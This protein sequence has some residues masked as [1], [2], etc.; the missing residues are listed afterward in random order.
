M[1]NVVILFTP[2]ADGRPTETPSQCL[3]EVATAS[4][5]RESQT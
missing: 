3:I 1:H 2:W 5:T 4:T